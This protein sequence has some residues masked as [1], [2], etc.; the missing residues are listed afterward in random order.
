M[1]YFIYQGN[2]N[3]CGF[4]SM[5]MLLALVNK[6]PGFLYLDKPTKRERYTFSD[7][8]AIAKD[9]GLFLKAY[10]YEPKS[11]LD[12]KTP[13]LALIDGNHLVLVKE[14]RKKKVIVYD[15]AE[16][17][18][19]LKH[20]EFSKRWNKMTLEID[21]FEKQNF[22]KK[23]P[24]L[25]PL[26]KRIVSLLFSFLSI[27]SLLVGFFFIKNDVYI[28]IP[29][30]MLALFAIF[31]LVEKWYLIKEINFFDNLYMPKYFAK[32][33]DDAISKY[34]EYTNR[35]KDFFQFDR[36]AYSSFG[37]IAVFIFVLVFNNLWN[38]IAVIFLL[39][40]ALSEKQ[41]FKSKDNEKELNLTKLENTLVKGDNKNLIPD[42]L[43]ISESSNSFALR[44]STRKCVN[45]FII[46]LLSLGMMIIS[47]EISV[48]F[49]IFNFGLFVILFDNI[50]S[51]LGIGDKSKKY[52]KEKMRFLDQCIL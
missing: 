15:P 17:T 30:I 52:L 19:A 14:M 49:V 16:G 13:F 11:P 27:A 24:E 31:E 10:E 50:D 48:N 35:K 6:N 33:N 46:I 36:K 47:K 22:V 39:L 37:I 3:D 45:A 18:V 25:L 44:L 9:Y 7:L 1:R 38:A 23:K 41:F 12:I 42:L 28:F 34:K 43:S 21:H 40:L 29:V 5:K 4:A 8:I 20:V 32:N 51:A 26:K 2:D